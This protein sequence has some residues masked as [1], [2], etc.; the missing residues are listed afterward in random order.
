MRWVR[1]IDLPTIQAATA[2]TPTPT[3]NTH[4]GVGHSLGLLAVT[5]IFLSV[6]EK[7]MDLDRVGSAFEWLVRIHMYVHTHAHPQQ[8]TSIYHKTN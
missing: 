7:A 4:Q 6:G 5:V 2:L 1:S 3:A 8:S